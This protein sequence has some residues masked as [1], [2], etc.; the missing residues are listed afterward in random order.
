MKKKRP[1]AEDRD[2]AEVWRKM[3]PGV[4][5]IEVDDTSK[6]PFYALA[7]LKTEGTTEIDFEKT[8]IIIRPLSHE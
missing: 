1:T 7:R 6:G 3:K 8:R 5:T 2:L 4:Y